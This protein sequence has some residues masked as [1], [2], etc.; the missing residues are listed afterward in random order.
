MPSWSDDL[1]GGELEVHQ[2]Q[3]SFGRPSTRSPTMLRC[4]C[5]VPAAMVID[6]A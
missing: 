2:R 6:S 3:R 4:T 5:D 1:V